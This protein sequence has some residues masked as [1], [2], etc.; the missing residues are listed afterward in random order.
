MPA[1]RAR[2][3]TATYEMQNVMW[4]IAIWPSE[5]FW[6]N[7]WAKKIS[8]LMPMMISGV[9][10]GSRSSV[11]VAPL[12]RNLSR[13][14]P[15]PSSEPRTVDADDRDD[16]DLERHPERVEQVAVGEQLRV[17]V[18]REARATRSSGASR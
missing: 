17:P 4:A 12:P 13:A 7:S 16:G 14:R 8:R 15:S 5:P 11:S 18:E 9:T 2:T 3:M 1:A 6:P 10:I